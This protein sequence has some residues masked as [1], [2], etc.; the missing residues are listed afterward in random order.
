MRT[1]INNIVQQV[2]KDKMFAK[3]IQSNTW[4]SGSST[5]V[6]PIVISEVSKQIIFQ[7]NTNKNVFKKFIE[8]TCVKHDML[9][10]GYFS[11]SDGSCPSEIVFYYK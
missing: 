1:D 2:A 3:Y 8:R 5:T 11:K 10:Y 9:T 7:L 6:Y 4:L